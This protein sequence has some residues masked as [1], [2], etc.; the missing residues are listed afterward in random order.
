MVAGSSILA[1]FHRQN[2]R[3][4]SSVDSI[5]EKNKQNVA[6]T[7]QHQEE[8]QHRCGQ[9][10]LK[11]VLTVSTRAKI[12][13]WMFQNVFENG[14]KHITLTTVKNFLMYFRGAKNDIIVRA[15]RLWCDSDV[16]NKYSENPTT[17]KLHRTIT[18][19]TELG[20]KSLDRK[21]KYGRGR[22]RADWVDA[23][24][25]ELCQEF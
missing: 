15:M 20:P 9:R 24:H 5:S 17:R 12:V 10:S 4:Q 3:P 13:A 22:K 21:V 1:V 16:C 11:H 2:A 19:D 6:A 14:P 23:L 8:T 18:R 7:M 25:P